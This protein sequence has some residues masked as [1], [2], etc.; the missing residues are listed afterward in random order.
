ML[1]EED[2]RWKNLRSPGGLLGLD[3][4]DLDF[5]L[6]DDFVYVLPAAAFLA[7]GFDSLLVG[8]MVLLS[9]VV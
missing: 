1:L 2:F 3:A 5:F 9:F 4:L 8:A 6:P 7:V